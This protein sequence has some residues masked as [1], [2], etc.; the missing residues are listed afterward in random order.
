MLHFLPGCKIALSLGR[1]VA[2]CDQALRKLEE[3]LEECQQANGKQR[4]AERELC[5]RRERTKASL[6][7]LE[8]GHESRPQPSAPVLPLKLS[9]YLCDLIYWYGPS[10]QN[11]NELTVFSEEAI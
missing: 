1:Q 10:K 7:Q 6:L 2:L 3:V 5:Q 8:M 9:S 11:L 4:P